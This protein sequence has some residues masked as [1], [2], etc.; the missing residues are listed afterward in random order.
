MIV[1]PCEASGCSSSATTCL[2]RIANRVSVQ[3]NWL[4]QNHVKDALQDFLRRPSSSEYL[5]PATAQGAKG[6]V[7]VDLHLILYD[8]SLFDQGTCCSVFLA[9]IAGGRSLA[10]PTGYFE[11]SNLQLELKRQPFRRPP[12]H[13]LVSGLIAATGGRIEYVV[14]DEYQETEQLFAAKL[15]IAYKTDSL[16]L[17]VRPSDAFTVAV[18]C[19]API[20][21]S[22]DVLDKAG[23]IPG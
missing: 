7:P 22:N 16:D 19:R 23:R 1:F 2:S 20:L 21:V 10:V 14:L 15:H 9:E 11:T 17:D 6:V 12:T 18:A 8:Q 5:A 13:R 3:E 4:C